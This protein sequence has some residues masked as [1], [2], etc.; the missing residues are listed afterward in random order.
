[1]WIGGK[2]VSYKSPIADLPSALDTELFLLG[3]LVDYPGTDRN[4]NAGI[5]PRFF[6]LAQDNGPHT[7]SL[8]AT[9]VKWLQNPDTDAWNRHRFAVTVAGNISERNSIVFVKRENDIAGDRC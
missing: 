7:K 3:L 2:P 9:L 8:D 5:S 6:A 1:M 4:E